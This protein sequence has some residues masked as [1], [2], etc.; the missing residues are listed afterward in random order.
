MF[1]VRDSNLKI[2][3]E[4]ARQEVF[5][6]LE[7]IFETHLNEINN[8]SSRWRFINSPENQAFAAALTIVTAQPGFF[9]SG[10][11]WVIDLKTDRLFEC[12]L[13]E[14]NYRGYPLLTLV[15]AFIEGVD[16][17]T[18]TTVSLFGSDSVEL[19]PNTQPLD[20]IR[21]CLEIYGVQPQNSS[22]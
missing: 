13:S 22:M 9:E 6:S 7:K 17:K 21:A 18:K 4:V 15:K 19:S 2:R 8:S 16:R 12:H 20:F 3:L 14:A 11:F 10:P 1:E 5:D